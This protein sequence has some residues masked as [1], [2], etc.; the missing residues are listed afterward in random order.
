MYTSTSKGYAATAVRNIV[1]TGNK[2]LGSGTGASFGCSVNDACD[3]ITVTNNVVVNND[4]PWGCKYIKTFATGIARYVLRA[5]C[6]VLRAAC[7]LRAV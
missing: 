3:N 1:F 4:D 5:A 2:V 6:C 7:V